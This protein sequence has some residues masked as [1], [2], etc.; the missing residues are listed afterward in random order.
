[1][2]KVIKSISQEVTTDST[3]LLVVT[4]CSPYGNEGDIIEVQSVDAESIIEKGFA[5]QAK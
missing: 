3:V 4:N 5:K 1:M 2:A